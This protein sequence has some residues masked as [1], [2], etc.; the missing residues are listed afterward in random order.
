MFIQRFVQFTQERVLAVS[1]S[2][3]DCLYILKQQVTTREEKQSLVAKLADLLF[4][5]SRSFLSLPQ[6]RY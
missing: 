6:L 5:S 4:L 3:T 2:S 1:P